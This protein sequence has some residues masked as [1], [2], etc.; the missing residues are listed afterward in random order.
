MNVPGV[1]E[2]GKTTDGT[3]THFGSDWIA[4]VVESSTTGGPPTRR[5][6]G[7]GASLVFPKMV[8]TELLAW[9]Y[10][11]ERLTDSSTNNCGSAFTDDASKCQCFFSAERL[12]EGRGVQLDTFN[13]EFRCPKNVECILEPP[14]E[15]IFGRFYSSTLKPGWKH[16]RACPLE[17]C[18]YDKSTNALLKCD[19][20]DISGFLVNLVISVYNL[21]MISACEYHPDAEFCLRTESATGPGGKLDGQANQVRILLYVC[22]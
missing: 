14:S 9:V 11:P 18:Y 7:T 12:K 21:K 22:M 5:L 17:R 13:P 15:D 3:H 19:I 2:E 1:N 6:Q 20:A 8:T 4:Q 10:D 16:D